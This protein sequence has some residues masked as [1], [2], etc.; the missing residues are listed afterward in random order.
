MERR[1]L[2]V[3]PLLTGILFYIIA[4][5]INL[6]FSNCDDVEASTQ[7]QTK[8][9]KEIE[10]PAPKPSERETFVEKLLS[11]FQ[12]QYSLFKK[13]T[14]TDGKYIYTTGNYTIIFTIDPKLQEKVKKIFKTYKLKYGAYVA[15]DPKT[16]KVLAAVSSIDY[17]DLTTKNT[18][19]TASTFKIITAAAALEEGIATPDT[20]LLCGGK[21]DSCSPT[22]WLSSPYK[23]KRNFAQSFATSANPFFGNL[24]RLLGEEKLLEYAKKFGFNRHDYNFPWGIIRKPLDDN[25]LAL[26]A[27]GLGETRTSPFHE[28]LIALT[29]ENNGTMLKPSLISTILKNGKV[30]Y[31]F[32]PQIDR[33]VISSK[34]AQEIRKMM[35]LTVKVG[36][37]SDKRYFRVLKRRYPYLT[38]GGKT[39]TLSELT[40]PEGR[41]EWFTGFLELGNKKLAFSSLAINGSRYYVTGYDLSALVAMS[42]AK[43]YKNYR[44]T[45]RR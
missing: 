36:T 12:M 34:T 2:I 33:N 24:G 39:G 15:L 5:T 4:S 7:I 1:K 38:I 41:C 18:F 8:V 40:Y 23:M 26:T 32:K 11:N 43:L 20:N 16:G 21:G 13:S 37:A 35:L 44:Y 42:F 27:A 14:L 31:S 30:I 10:K 22:V 29:I 45:C 25:D 6:L 28:A 19:P 3:Y 9:E 17:P